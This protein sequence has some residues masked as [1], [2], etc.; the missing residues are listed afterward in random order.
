MNLGTHA[1]IWKC[2]LTLLSKIVILEKEIEVPTKRIF[3]FWNDDFF[4]EKKQGKSFYT[5]LLWWFCSWKKVS[6]NDEPYELIWDA[7]F[8]ESWNFSK[9]SNWIPEFYVKMQKKNDFTFLHLFQ[10]SKKKLLKSV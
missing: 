4:E 8:V 2:I 1:D 10:R 9:L 5:F 6:L 7:A 3:P